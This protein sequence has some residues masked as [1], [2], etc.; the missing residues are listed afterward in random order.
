MEERTGWRGPNESQIVGKE[1]K[2]AKSAQ[3]SAGF[4]GKT[5]TYWTCRKGKSGLSATERA[6]GKTPEPPLPKRKG[7]E[8]SVQSIRS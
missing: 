4:S 7:T 1:K 3:N 6:V 5:G 8:P 2:A